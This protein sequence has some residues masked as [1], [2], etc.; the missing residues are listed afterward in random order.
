MTPSRAGDADG[1]YAL[2]QG[3]MLERT[4]R[5]VANGLVAE[6]LIR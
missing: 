4:V 6:R 3:L 5:P 1:S 2:D